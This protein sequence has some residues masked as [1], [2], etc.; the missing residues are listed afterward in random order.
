MRDRFAAEEQAKW[1][2]V[3][4]PNA[5]EQRRRA[6]S[7]E[8]CQD[9]GTR[10]CG[11]RDRL[12]TT[13]RNPPI[14]ATPNNT[15]RTTPDSSQKLSFCAR[16]ICT[17]NNTNATSHAS[18]WVN[19]V[20]PTMQFSTQQEPSTTYPRDKSG[21]ANIQ[22][23]GEQ[24]TTRPRNETLT[25]PLPSRQTPTRQQPASRTVKPCE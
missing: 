2:L 21:R 18:L 23:R 1:V 4:E 9:A 24:R 3:G 20:K 16:Y 22:P 12:R 8:V 5:R 10:G 7:V 17:V 19:A 15:K 6:T 25:R 13:R 11:I 14:C